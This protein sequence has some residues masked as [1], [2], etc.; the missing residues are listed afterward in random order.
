MLAAEAK[1]AENARCTTIRIP[2][3]HCGHAGELT[4]K[5]RGLQQLVHFINYVALGDLLKDVCI[6]ATSGI[7]LQ[8]EYIVNTTR[9]YSI[10]QAKD[11][12]FL[13]NLLF[14]VF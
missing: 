10:C 7:M 11:D 12:P 6:E 9:D 1:E 8:E 13:T 4:Y 3:R 5:P 14:M 2:N